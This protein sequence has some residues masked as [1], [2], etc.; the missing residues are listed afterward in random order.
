MA[1]RRREWLRLAGAS[2]LIPT[3]VWAG[4]S[5]LLEPGK[6]FRIS[7]RLLPE[8]HV[9]VRLLVAEG[10]YL[11]R[12]KLRF[13]IEP[14]SAQLGAPQLPAGTVKDDEF[15]GKVETYRGE[16]TIRIP[17][18]LPPG[19]DKLNLRVVSQ[20][21]AD[22]GICYTPQ[23]QRLVLNAMGDEALPAPPRSLLDSLEG[24]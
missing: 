21:C 1:M 23:D 24:R 15:F 20:G 12:D 9:L 16:I 17:A 7:A 22:A 8:S 19:A 18:R 3:G 10:Y 14:A 13:S 5:D 4:A 2:C 11:Y 6:A